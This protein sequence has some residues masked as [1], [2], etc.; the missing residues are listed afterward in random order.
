MSHLCASDAR[1]HDSRAGQ[2]SRSLPHLVL[3]SPLLP[4][5]VCARVGGDAVRR[6]IGLEAATLAWAFVWIG[7]ESP[8]K[9][10]A[11]APAVE[12]S[13]CPKPQPPPT[14]DV[15]W[16]DAAE[17]CAKAQRGQPWRESVPPLGPGFVEPD[18]RYAARVQTFLRSLA[19]RSEPYAWL[20]DADWRLTGSY[21]GCPPD[22][23]NDGPH[24]AVRIYYSP[25]II[26]WM[27]SARLGENQLPDAKAIPDGAVIIKEMI[28]PDRVELA[29]VPGS[30]NLWI[31]PKGGEPA[32]WY[33]RSFQSWTIMIKAARGASDGWYWAFFDRTSTG[34]PPIDARGAFAQTP[35]PGQGGV[36]VTKPPGDDW[37]P[38]YWNYSTNDVQFPN[39]QFGNYCVYCHASAQGEGT[40]ASFDNLLGREIRYA[41]VK[42]A[43]PAQDFED[44]ARQQPS[45]PSAKAAADTDP[46]APFPSPRSEPLPGFR[47]TFPELDPPYSEVWDSRLPAQTYDHTVAKLGPA[48][49]KPRASEFLTSDQCQG[50]HEAGG[51]G[52]LD[53]PYMVAV[54]G[55]NQIDLSPWAE[56]GASPMGMAGRDPIFHAQLELERN[57][58]RQQPGLAERGECIDNLCLHCHGGAGARQY[59]IDTAGQAPGKRCDDFLP[60]PAERSAADLDGKPFTQEMVFAWRD[61]S[62]E[63]AS[64]GGLARDGITCTMCHRVANV[65]LDQANL[66]K[67]FTGNFRTGPPDKLFGPFPNAD[68]KPAVLPKPM[69]FTLGITPELGTQIATSELCGTCHTIY[70]PVFDDRG[71][72]AGAAYE[73]TTYLEWLLSSFSALDAPGGYPSGATKSCQDCHMPRS[74]AKRALTTGIA[75]IQDT[76]YPAVDFLRPAAEVDVP[77][78]PYSRHRLQ[79]L[80]AFLNAYVQQFPLLLGY[81]QQ[82]FMNPNV[83]APLLTSRE[84]ALE[85]ARTE[86]A[87]LSVAGVRRTPDG[88][89]ATVQVQNLA[90]HDLP[91][92]V[93]FRRLFIEFLVLDAQGGTL[94][95]SGRTNAIGVL[96]QGRSE[97]PLPTEFWGAGADGLPF[98]PHHQVVAS[99]SQ[100]QIYEEAVQDSSLDFTSSF[101]HRYWTIKDNRLRPSGWSPARVRDPQR[102]AEYGDATEPGTGPLRNWWPRPPTPQPY[103]NAKF[104]GIER[105]TDTAGDPDYDLRVHPDGLTGS[106]SVVYR[107]A[108]APELR[109]RAARVRVTLYS[110]S[111][112]PSYL[113]ERFAEAARPGAQR[114]AAVRLYYLAG[115]LNTDA[116]ASDGEPYLSGYKLRVAQ[117]VE[118]AI[119]TS[120]SPGANL[121][122]P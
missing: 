21:E 68:S 122:L 59:N 10:S 84:S 83:Q 76:R 51:S 103:R 69:E 108:L 29:L 28:D 64:Y 36:P 111:A 101:V 85:V 106:D 14:P 99:E 50:C 60:P 121:I 80:N 48:G 66:R 90:G 78:R 9:G 95:A 102:R 82:D 18:D 19:Y 27:C 61:E 93:G 57:L 5:A 11:D 4:V 8:E 100:A 120:R 24:P 105:Y 40:F 117:P 97:A 3:T 65:D 72:K 41:W 71:A 49:G 17:L 104:P 44:H 33:D 1:W 34:N 30:Q 74:Y 114:R 32:D 110:Q 67:T 54:D 6:S 96:L 91:S 63:L 20:R 94:W 70:L 46:R 15:P 88:I 112:P 22:G 55:E 119:E 47:Q 13:R 37:Y 35:Y 39:Y 52:Q 53:L 86:T 92:G 89:E 58:A 116:P 107:A 31:A 98:Q 115:H 2:T 38:T 45:A 43:S 23:N 79:G 56:W 42:D 77:E 12:A 75:N 87:T 7:C 26:D 25:E 62:P 118:T 16:K 81:R 113:K 109:A 73:Q